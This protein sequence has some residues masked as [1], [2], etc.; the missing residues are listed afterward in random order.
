VQDPGIDDSLLSAFGTRLVETSVETLLLD[1]LL[2]VCKERGWLKA[3][4]K[5]R[6]DLTHG[7]LPA[8]CPGWNESERRCER[9]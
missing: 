1:R 9:L 6:T 8:P 7:D 4:G 3:G 2:E 5:Q